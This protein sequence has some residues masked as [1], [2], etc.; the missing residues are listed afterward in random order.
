MK[1]SVLQEKLAEQILRIFIRP[2]LA[3]PRIYDR[4]GLK[5]LM[6]TRAPYD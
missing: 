4:K 2:I 3:L 6:V 5:S 1:H